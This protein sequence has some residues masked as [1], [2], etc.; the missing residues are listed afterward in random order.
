M[1]GFARDLKF[2]E[3]VIWQNRQAFENAVQSVARA[4]DEA[5]RNQRQRNHEELVAGYLQRYAL[6]NDTIGFFGPVAWGRI[7]P[8]GPMLELDYG[9]SPLKKRQTYFENWAI[10]KIAASISLHK[11]MD[12]WIPPRLVPEVFIEKEILKRPGMAPVPLSKLE[13][14]VLLLCDGTATPDDILRVLRSDSRFHGCTEQEIREVLNAKAAEGILIWRFL[15]PVEVNA[16][17]GLRRQLLRIGNPELR[18]I[19]F[20]YLDKVEVARDR[21]GQAA[22]NPVQLNHALRE[23]ELAFEEITKIPGTRNHGVTYGGRTVLY[24]DC[25]RD[26]EIKFTPDILR[27]IVPALSLLLQSLRWFMQSTALEFDRLFKQ[28]YQ[29]LASA[30]SGDVILQEWWQYTEPKLLGASSLGEIEKAF[31]QK[32]GEI[33]SIAENESTMQFE[34]CALQNKVERLF[35]D[36]GASYYPVRYFCPD[37]MLAAESV[38]AIMKG[39]V[40]YV[41]GEVH[42]GKNTLCHAALVEQHPDRRELVEATQ[43]DLSKSCLKIINTLADETTM[44]RTSESVFRPADYFLATTADSVPPTGYDSHPMSDLLLKEQGKELEAVSRS[45]GRR[46]HILEAFSD[47]LFA[48]V[49]NKAK[50]VPPSRHVPRVRIDKLVVHRET[51]RFCSDELNF[52]AEKDEAQ[53]FLGARKWVKDSGVPREMFVKST[54]EVKPFYVNMDS[55]VLVEILCRTVRRMNSSNGSRGEIVFSEM[56]PGAKQLWL[57]DAEGASYT[58]E[59]RF[60]MVDLKARFY[61]TDHVI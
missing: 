44:V 36:L 52:A 10:D 57:R 37:I 15:V 26:L 50:W 5:A 27:P 59:L 12:W 14:A 35:P 30:T 11:G 23:M 16:E 49:M 3:A 56:L 41:L 61:S 17:I 46:F 4:S 9:P 18:N 25:Q 32:W 55:P 54:M 43:W 20:S 29:E 53:R 45:S 42:S 31:Q 2:Q 28:T 33:I 6:K 1:R 58:S 13:L 8:D 51:W 24:E 48:F 39:E 19:A 22:G 7:A 38:E 21:V 47:L 34:S 60:A 40:L